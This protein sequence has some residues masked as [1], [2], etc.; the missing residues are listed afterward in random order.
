MFHIWLTTSDW[1]IQTR[2]E[3][4]Y[5]D[6]APWGGRWLTLEETR[7]EIGIIHSEFWKGTFDPWVTGTPL[8]PKNGDWLLAEVISDIGCFE[9]DVQKLLRELSFDTRKE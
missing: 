2:G 1:R 6:S 9:P 7:K 3:P 8:N 4:F 5:L